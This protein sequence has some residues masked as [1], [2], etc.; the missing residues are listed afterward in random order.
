[1]SAKTQIAIETPKKIIR[2]GNAHIG[3]SGWH[4]P[5][6]RG[7]Y[8]PTDLPVKKQLN[9]YGHTF[10]TTEI[11]SSFYRLPTAST[12]QNWV[13]A[14]PSAFRF[15]PKISRFITHAKKLN[16]PEQ[17]CNRFFEV[18]DPIRKHCGPIL[19]QLPAL[20]TFHP[21]KADHFFSFLTRTYK[22]WLFSLETRHASWHTGEAIAL[23][24]KYRIGWVIAESGSRWASAEI[25]TSRHI[26]IRFH[27]PAGDYASSY[28][29][30][31]LAVYAQ[32]CVEWMEQGKN[33]WIFFNN[34]VHG[35]AIMNARRLMEI[36]TLSCK[37]ES[38]KGPA[39]VSRPGPPDGNIG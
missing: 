28:P 15:C 3:T 39:A 7:I 35:F 22:G 17:S 19:I 36:I 38:N 32:K 27:G 16:D 23:L 34:D 37:Y 12:V 5:H 14:V 1:M 29:D 21:E 31:I 10:K 13:D 11:N 33:L 8:Y 25:I 26:Y 4:Y 2:P 9:F 24:K 20:L 30:K 6:W 18:F